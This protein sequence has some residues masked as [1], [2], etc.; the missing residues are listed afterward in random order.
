MKDNDI[1]L[2]LVKNCIASSYEA[3]LFKDTLF[4]NKENIF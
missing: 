3:T 4:N 2:D 1:E